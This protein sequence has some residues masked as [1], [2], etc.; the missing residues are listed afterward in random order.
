MLYTEQPLSC[1]SKKLQI[2][3]GNFRVFHYFTAPIII[4]RLSNLF[5]HRCKLISFVSLCADK[6]VAE[7]AWDGVNEHLIAAKLMLGR[8]RTMPLINESS[9]YYNRSYKLNFES[10]E[11]CYTT[12]KEGEKEK[13]ACS[14]F[15]IMAEENK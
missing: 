10:R 3:T 1:R 8:Y 15:V 11:L 14:L 9:N 2:F 13:R 6:K 5:M 7:I 4:S 12:R